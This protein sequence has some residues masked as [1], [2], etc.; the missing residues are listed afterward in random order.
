MGVTRRLLRQN[1]H[2]AVKVWRAMMKTDGK[3]A[4][5]LFFFLRARFRF[6]VGSRRRCHRRAAGCLG[7]FDLHREDSPHEYSALIPS[8]LIF[9]YIYKYFLVLILSRANRPSKNKPSA[10]N[11]VATGGFTQRHTLIFSSRV[12]CGTTLRV[13]F[14]GIVHPNWKFQPFKDHRSVDTGSGGILPIL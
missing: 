7:V 1:K 3:K 2:E 10:L 13:S 6:G 11:T 14:K 8:A 4:L 5:P 12:I 9:K